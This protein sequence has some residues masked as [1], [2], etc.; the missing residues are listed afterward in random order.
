MVNQRQR[1]RGRPSYVPRTYG[2]ARDFPCLCLTPS[3]WYGTLWY[4]CLP[5]G[6]TATLVLRHNACLRW[7]GSRLP[8]WLGTAAG[9]GTWYHTKKEKSWST[10]ALCSLV[11]RPCGITPRRGSILPVRNQASKEQIKKVKLSLSFITYF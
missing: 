3:L 11:R 2:R 10:R 4:F 6:K 7:R 8:L 5:H 1:K 9:I